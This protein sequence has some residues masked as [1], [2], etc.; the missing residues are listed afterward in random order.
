MQKLKVSECGEVCLVT[1][2]ME[3]TIQ[4][5]RRFKQIIVNISNE[6]VSLMCIDQRSDR[7]TDY[8]SKE[9]VKQKKKK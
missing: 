5:Y 3:G 7:I 2:K 1:K 8:G 6:I 4:K 9:I